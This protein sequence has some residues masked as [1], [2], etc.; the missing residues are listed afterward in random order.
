[1]N[2]EVGVYIYHWLALLIVTLPVI[3]IQVNNHAV[4]HNDGYPSMIGPISGVDSLTSGDAALVLVR[5]LFCM[6]GNH[7]L[8][9]VANAVL[10][11]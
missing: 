9:Q 8:L 3:H 7:C 11:V 1:M 4:L 6:H 10:Y 2:P 5:L